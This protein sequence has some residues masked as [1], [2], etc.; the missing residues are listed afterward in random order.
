MT[1]PFLQ[2]PPGSHV[3]ASHGEQEISAVGLCTLQLTSFRRLSVP[4]IESHG[5]ET[6]L[7]ILDLESSQPRS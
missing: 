1:R 5:L 2:P 6:F 3:S 4:L 7:R